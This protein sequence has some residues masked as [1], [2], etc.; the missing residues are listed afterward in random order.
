MMFRAVLL[1]NARLSEKSANGYKSL[2]EFTRNTLNHLH[3]ALVQ[4]DEDAERFKLIGL[5][6]N[7]ISVTGNIK[8]D[9]TIDT[10]RKIQAKELKAQLSNNGQHPIFIAASTHHGEDEQ[11]LSAFKT[12]KKQHPGL[13]LVIVPRH[14]ERFDSVAELIE[15]AG[16][17]CLRRSRDEMQACDVML[18]DTMGELLV[19]LGAADIAFVGGSLID[20]G[21]HN[22]IE[23]AA[24]SLPVLS[25]PSYFN[26][27]EVVSLL[28]K[29]DAISI[30]PNADAL[31]K[32][33]S[34]LLNDSELAK[35]MGERGK[36]V[37]E[38][39]RGATARLIQA[40]DA[41]LQG[42]VL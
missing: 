2:G 10:E 15:Q 25:G 17:T 14:P 7:K 30:L 31:A 35:E 41:T 42:E 26:F 6:E 5:D 21:G 29:K 16:W 38:Q 8:F 32:K 18:G 24:W 4:N 36:H 22:Y 9:L 27:A 37:A 28:Y 19:L 20:N 40:I 11:I 23:P 1:C 12:L 33:V 13:T 34:I 3:H 39:N